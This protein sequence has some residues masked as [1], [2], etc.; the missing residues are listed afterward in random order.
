MSSFTTPHRFY[1]F[2]MKNGR[3]KLAY[4]ATPDDALEILSY[5]LSEEEMDL[6]IRNEFERIS[7][8]DL[9]KYIDNLG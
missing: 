2:R 9:Q 1:C 3:Q 4:G 5:R 7:Q 8:K 6:I